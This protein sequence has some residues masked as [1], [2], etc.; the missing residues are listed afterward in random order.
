MQMQGLVKLKVV[1]NGRN[2]VNVVKKRTLGASAQLVVRQK[3]HLKLQLVWINDFKL[4][5]VCA[6]FLDF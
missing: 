5:K 1:N 3:L 4:L 6:Y 2:L